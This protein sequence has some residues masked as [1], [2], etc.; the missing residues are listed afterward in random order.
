MPVGLMSGE[1]P[2]FPTQALGGHEE[3][4]R[5]LDTMGVQHEETEGHY[6]APEKSVVIYGLPR[7]Q[8]YALGQ[9]YGQEA[10]IHN[11]G[12]KREFIYT[13]GPLAG[14]M[15]PGLPSFE[16]WPEGS[17]PPEDNFTKLPGNGY[18][19]LHFD[20][21]HVD[22]APVM[23]NAPQPAP[24]SPPP[25]EGVEGSA[26][27]PE[28]VAAEPKM[29]KAALW[30]RFVAL[31]KAYVTMEQ[32]RAEGAKA[33]FKHPHFYK[34]HDGHTDQHYMG[35]ASGGVLISQKL[36]KHDAPGA[37]KH[38]HIDGA[39]PNK[40]AEP[41][42]FDQNAKAG[43]KSYAHFALPFGHIDNDAKTR[44]GSNLFHYDYNG[45]NDAVNK[46]VAAHGFQPYYA[47]GKFGKPDLAKRNYN[48]KHLMIYDPTSASA[49]PSGDP[50]YTDSWRKTHEL[51]HALVYPHLNSIYG[52]GRRIGKLG[53]HR[54]LN[55]ALRAVHWEHLA[56]HKQRELN[57]QLGI[58]VPDEL[59][60]REYNTVMHDAAHRAVTGKFTEPS[61]EGFTPHSHAVPLETSLGL[62]REAA[63]NLGLTGMHD[64]VKKSEGAISVAD[65]KKSLNAHEALHE[66][67]KGLTA[68]VKDW[69]Q[70]CVDLRKAELAKGLT[71]GPRGGSMG[72]GGGAPAPAPPPPP[73]PVTSAPPTAGSNRRQA[74]SMAETPM[75]K[76]SPPGRKEEVEKLKA[77]GLP[78]SEAF[79]IAWKQHDAEKGEMPAAAGGV[80]DMTMSED[81]KLE[82]YAK[83]E[84]KPGVKKT[85]GDPAAYGPGGSFMPKSER[86]DHDGDDLDKK[87]E[88]YAKG[89][90]PAGADPTSPGPKPGVTPDDKKPKMQA[91]KTQE[92]GND[93]TDVKPMKKTALPGAAPAAP[94]MPGA[95]A[96]AGGLPKL[97]KL[98]G[99]GKPAAGGMPKPA[100]PAAPAGGAKPP[101]MGAGQPALKTE[102]KKAGMP[103]AKSPAGTPPGPS[104]DVAGNAMKI[105]AAAPSRMSARDATAQ[106]V[107]LPGVRASVGNTMD[108]MLASKPAA[109]PATLAPGT[110]LPAS[111]GVKI[112]GVGAPPPKPS[113][114]APMVQTKAAAMPAGQPASAL[115]PPPAAARPGA[116]LPGAHLF[117]KPAAPKVK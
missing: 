86:N 96:A 1:N 7:D 52:E 23:P 68:Q 76:K 26:G 19:R 82:A 33:P 48:T 95:G 87:L 112:P 4:K 56:A 89:E 28:H 114:A 8:L 69:E 106:A 66:L 45:K 109:Q 16:H 97:P 53:A 14:K 63:R 91:A 18:I 93:G 61:E 65:D 72:G 36:R 100:A 46:L 31:S 37:M 113:A 2:R 22:A 101:A 105:A 104:H 90:M 43:V 20:F 110:T 5:D 108:N 83:G 115:T 29:S 47:G 35:H 67:H 70:K 79:G 12:G 34:W 50:T 24:L 75:A 73:A 17:E 44:G 49:D 11:E 57:Q 64:L 92:A 116:A 103:P 25:P 60:N 85:L 62:V 10:V 80:G 41:D 58:H 78:A 107:K 98:P 21:D 15:H 77:K 102:M 59:F 88:A 39:I 42:Y 30:D 32:L 40:P 81:E 13:N 94:K 111:P 38:P 6:G 51:A 84:Y 54:T 74:M 3:L 99:V 71:L 9:K 27:V 55:E 117:A